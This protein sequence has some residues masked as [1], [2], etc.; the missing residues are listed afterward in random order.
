[1]LKTFLIIEFLFGYANFASAGLLGILFTTPILFIIILSLHSSLIIAEI[2]ELIPFFII[3]L[4]TINT[5]L[6]LLADFIIFFVS[7][8]LK[9]LKSII[10][11]FILFLFKNSNDL[12]HSIIPYEKLTKVMSSPLLSICA[13]PIG[14]R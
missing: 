4:S 14:I 12:R 6:V 3:P 7:K 11:G 13:L 2:S 10:S 9:D 8:G 1:M 5:F